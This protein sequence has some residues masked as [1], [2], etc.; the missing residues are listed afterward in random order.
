MGYGVDKGVVGRVDSRTRG[1]QEREMLREEHGRLI[2][3]S[4]NRA[5]KDKAERRGE[6]REQAASLTHLG[7]GSRRPSGFQASAPVVTVAQ[8]AEARPSARGRR[9]QTTWTTASTGRRPR[10]GEGASTRQPAA[11]AAVGAS[12]AAG[13]P[14]RAPAVRTRPRLTIRRRSSTFGSRHR[15]ARH[16]R[17]D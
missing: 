17:G 13:A 3:I 6:T 7:S 9:R 4:L 11:A 8:G 16:G 14:C 15:E 12:A 2:E 1:R 10:T 5:C